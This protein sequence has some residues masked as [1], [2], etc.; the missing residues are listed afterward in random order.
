VNVGPLKPSP[1]PD[2][3]EVPVQVKFKDQTQNGTVFVTKDGK[4]LLRG[5]L[6]DMAVDPFASNRK[7]LT[8]SGSPSKG[9]T[10]A[11]VTVVDFS[12]FECPHCRALFDVLK[13]VE[14]EFPQVRFVFKNFPLTSIHPWAMTAA[15]AG[16]CAFKMSPESYWKLQAQIFDNQDAI[17]ADSAWSQITD[18]LSTDG[19]A[20]DSLHACMVAPETKSA[21]DADIAEG[22]SLDVESTPTLFI[23][24]RPIVGGDRELLEGLIKFELARAK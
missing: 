14:P 10:D 18:Y 4:Y 13:T 21:V 7:K 1:I 11:K 16:E 5:E 20:A 8:L 24:G 23:N 12:D 2:L 9:P 6:R 19:I 15:Q 17:T 3:F 22:K